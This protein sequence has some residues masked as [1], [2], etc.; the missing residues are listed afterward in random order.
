[1]LQILENSFFNEICPRFFTT[2]VLVFFSSKIP[3]YAYGNEKLLSLFLSPERCDGTANSQ[4]TP[5]IP[6]IG[7]FC[8]DFHWFRFHLSPIIILKRHSPIFYSSKIS[9]IHELKHYL[10]SHII[11][12]TKPEFTTNSLMQQFKIRIEFHGNRA[13]NDTFQTKENQINIENWNDSENWH[14]ET[15][16]YEIEKESLLVSHSLMKFIWLHL[17]NEILGPAFRYMESSTLLYTAT[18][19]A[20]PKH[21]AIGKIH[22]G[23]QITNGKTAFSGFVFGK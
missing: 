21:E 4:T 1:M 3:G 8:N 5:P 6:N 14:G 16:R 23:K 20:K 7:K 17:H 10:L 18:P 2:N 11:T 13:S 19:R 15:I 12:I 9:Y 22:D